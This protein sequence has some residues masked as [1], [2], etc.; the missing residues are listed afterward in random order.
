M[1]RRIRQRATYANVTASIALFIALG[2][3]S[4]AALTLPRNSVGSPQ[5]RS[6][7]VRASELRT[8]AVASRD[9][10][11]RSIRL[12]DVST[13]ARRSLRGQQGPV[14]PAGPAGTT[15]RAAVSKGGAAV[16]GN[17]RGVEHVS[18]TNEYSV[19]FDRDVGSCVA[20]ATLASVQAGPTLEE[21]EPGRITVATRGD[22]AVV[23]T[24]AANGTPAEQP[25]HVMLA[26]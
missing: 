23:R 21:P 11:N 13:S 6:Q 25:F 19:A 18:G 14:G 1:I 10:R 20:T 22:R 24:F 2:G 4:Y 17:S 3:T 12:A 5:I 15:L 9:I 26:C 7:A 8:G 16:T